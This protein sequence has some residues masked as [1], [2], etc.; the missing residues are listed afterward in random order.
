MAKTTATYDE[1][2]VSERVVLHKGDL[3]ALRNVQHF[4]LGRQSDF[5][6][7]NALR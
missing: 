1:Y 4:Q 6:A 2:K 7:F 3:L 5:V